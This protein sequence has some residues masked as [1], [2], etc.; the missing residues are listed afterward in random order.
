MR[1]QRLCPQKGAGHADG[2]DAG[3]T[4]VKQD[5]A[6]RLLIAK[7]SLYLFVPTSAVAKRQLSDLVVGVSSLDV[8]CLTPNAIELRRCWSTDWLRT[9]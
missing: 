3:Q 8:C 9:L 4:A 1:A 2:A 7:S 5:K 6:T